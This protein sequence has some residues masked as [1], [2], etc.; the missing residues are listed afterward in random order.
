MLGRI[1]PL[2]MEAGQQQGDQE[3][4]TKEKKHP[5]VGKSIKNQWRGKGFIW[6]TLIEA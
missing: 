3:F 6:M 4:N 1:L 5:K 2:S